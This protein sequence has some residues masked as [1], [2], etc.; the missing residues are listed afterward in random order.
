VAALDRARIDRGA[1][2]PL[3]IVT[4]VRR[5]V[6]LGLL[7]PRDAGQPIQVGFRGRFRHALVDIL[8]CPVLEPVLFAAT[9]GL[10]AAAAEFLRPGEMAAASLTRTDS[11]V[12]LLLEAADRP[13]LAALEALAEFAA[14][15][16]L[17]RIVWRCR[18]GDTLV[19]ER[20]PVRVLYSGFAVPFPPG[21]FLQASAAAER[22]LTA[23]VLAGIG[24]AY[25]VLDLFAGI[26]AFTFALA[27]RGPV[28]A[29]EGDAAAVTALGRAAAAAP[30]ITVECRDLARDPLPSDALARYSAVVFDPPRAGAARQAAA[31][32][33]AGLD[34]VVAVSC[35][36]A[37]FARDAAALLASG[38]RLERLVPIDQFVWTQHLELVAVFRR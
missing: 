29:V 20:R 22:L 35:N 3:Q 34:T 33:N 7:R 18:G 36:P 4:P 10:P 5:R 13:G 31:L 15:D 9:G 21:G 26:G 24:N 32:A 23:E 30:G 37:T 28:H 8:E 12:D 11:G 27:E 2:A 38:F 14:A 6:R 25:P 16:D 17:A 19:V 1:V